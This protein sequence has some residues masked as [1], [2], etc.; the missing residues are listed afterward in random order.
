MKT[1]NIVFVMLAILFAI[2]ISQA[3]NYKAPKIDAAGKI[4]DKEGKHIGTITKEG[5]ISDAMGTKVAYVD[6]EGSLVDVKTGKKLGKAE[7]NGNFISAYAKT[8]DD[9]WV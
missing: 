6:A 5:V 3:Q 9:R 2:N 4:M 7:K 1:K 8:S